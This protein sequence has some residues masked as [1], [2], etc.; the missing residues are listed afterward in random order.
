MAMKKAGKAVE[1]L[2][3]ATRKVA[4][5][6]VKK[7]AAKVAA[8]APGKSRAKAPP[9]PPG[10]HIITPSLVVRGAEQA[11]EFY[12][13]AFGAKAR[14]RMLAPDGKV[15]HSEI[16]IGDSIIM[17]SD[18][19]PE[20]GESSPEAL[21]GTASS[22]M[23]YTKDVDALFK[24]AVDAGAKPTMP[25]ADMFWGDRYGVVTDPFG[26]RWQMATHKEDLS[27]R[28]AQRRA[29]AAMSSPP[30]PRSR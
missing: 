7:V 14:S 4:A 19:F 9:I 21:G 26:H 23:F 27:P 24:R 5:K 8:K 18:E 13:I 16:K 25:V 11:I 22:L 12:K 15:L 17:I 20:M 29:E 28:E 10:Y 3:E 6:V 1:K 2:R 30:P